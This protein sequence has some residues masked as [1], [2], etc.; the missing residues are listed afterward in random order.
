MNTGFNWASL[1]NGATF[2]ALVNIL[3][4]RDD[5]KTI[6]FTK[7][8]PDGGFDAVSPDWSTAYQAK[9]HASGKASKAFVDAKSEAKKAAK[10]RT[11]GHARHDLWK[12]VTTWKLITNI[13]FGPDERKKWD[14]EIKPLFKALGIEA[15]W[16]THAGLEERLAKHRDVAECF[17]EGKTRTWIS[18]DEFRQAA[19]DG[20]LGHPFEQPLEMRQ[21][22]LDRVLAFAREPDTRILVADGPGGVGKTRF[23][24]EAALRASETGLFGAV[25]VSSKT[26]ERSD[27]WYRGIVAEVPALVLIDEP[28]DPAFIGVLID[29]LRTRAK[30]WKVIVAVRSPNHPVLKPLRAKTLPILST[31]ALELRPLP[32]EGA[33]TVATNLLRAHAKFDPD[34]EAQAAAWLAKVSGRMPIW[35]TVGARLLKERGALGELPSDRWGLAE[36]YFDEIVRRGPEGIATPAQLTALL[37]WIAVL[38]PV[39]RKDDGMMAFLASGAEFASIGDLERALIS[40]RARRVVAWYGVDD[41]LVEIRPDVMR[42]YIV[43]QWLT[44]P[45]DPDDPAGPRTPSADATDL[46][47]RMIISVTGGAPVPAFRQAAIALG[48]LEL[49][50][51]PNLNLLDPLAD[52]VVAAANAAKDAE[53]QRQILSIAETFGPFRPRAFAATSKALRLSNVPS[54]TVSYG[55]G[56]TAEVKRERVLSALPWALFEVAHYASTPAERRAIL[57][58]L[59]ALM[60]LEAASSGRSTRRRN[61]GKSAEEVLPRLLGA[62]RSVRTSYLPEGAALVDDMLGELEAGRTVSPVKAR[63]LLGPLLSVKTEDDYAEGDSLVITRGTLFVEGEAGKKVVERTDRLWEALERDALDL[64]TRLLIWELLAAQTS[65]ASFGRPR[66]TKDDNEDVVAPPEPVDPKIDWTFLVRT[67]LE[68]TRDLA[69]RGAFSQE[70]WFAARALWDWHADHDWE[71]ACAGPAKES[72]ALFRADPTR[73]QLADLLLADMPDGALDVTARDLAARDVPAIEDFFAKALAFIKDSKNEWRR[74]LVWHIGWRM[75]ELDP[76]PEAVRRYSAHVISAGASHPQ[77][78]LALAVIGASLDRLRAQGDAGGLES[79]LAGVLSSEAA[80]EALRAAIRGLYIETTPAAQARLMSVDLEMLAKHAP[81]FAEERSTRFRLLGLAFPVDPD[82]VK[83][84]AHAAF[85]EVFDA[86]PWSFDDALGYFLQGLHPFLLVHGRTKAPLRQEDYAWIEGLA[87]WLPEVRDLRSI[88]ELE[89]LSK[90]YPKF[91]LSWLA[92][93]IEARRKRLENVERKTGEH[94]L[95]SKAPWVITRNF[96]FADLV[97]P[98]DKEGAVAEAD[99]DALV[100]LLALADA[101]HLVSS[102]LPDLLRCLDPHGRVLPDLVKAKLE[103]LKDPAWEDVARMAVY[104]KKYHPT[105][106]AWRGIALAACRVAEARLGPKE[107]MKVYSHLSNFDTGVLNGK[108]GE[109]HQHWGDAVEAA[110]DALAS[111]GDGPLRGLLTWR[112]RIAERDLQHQRERLE[113]EGYLQEEG[114]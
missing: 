17:F 37:R 39:S 71:A 74:Q 53:E 102:F 80:P 36:T 25:Y 72:E 19:A 23:L 109:V 58:E 113:E 95:L 31:P 66:P 68:R 61:D 82:A 110:K 38:Q 107:T 104:A 100:R 33:L 32:A 89:D 65:S 42:D 57:D 15:E 94:P 47:K 83:P 69:K 99:R 18:L 7:E 4:L 60:E 86:D 50:V 21:T 93:L 27:D 77:F 22:E 20:I 45:A 106:S 88:Y 43:R 96:P 9:Y 16:M 105:S 8:G 28:Q 13:S 29:Q 108:G 63:F 12:N 6:V 46:V 51:E 30:A 76:V 70:E 52:A 75:G 10:Y 59:V 87:S 79:E 90:G 84:L 55:E 40:L 92:D 24:Y 101:E 111:E 3:L 62:E 97:E 98:V 5:P 48:R 26:A 91:T 54:G 112:L 44:H 34:V 35:I 81:L 103:A 11:P 73:R 78:D 85:E 2:H 114:A 49:E 41:R 14:D 67:N 64:A 1:Q 56:L